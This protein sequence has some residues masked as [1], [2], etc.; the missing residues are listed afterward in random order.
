MPAVLAVAISASVYKLGLIQD[1]FVGPK[2][3]LSGHSGMNA[4]CG[5][6]GSRRWLEYAVLPGEG[7]AMT[8]DGW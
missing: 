3:V 1:I 6:S 7:H 4:A 5:K 8:M 2:S